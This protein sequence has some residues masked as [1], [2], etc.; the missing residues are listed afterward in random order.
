MLHRLRWQLNLA[1][2]R[3]AALQFF[4]VRRVDGETRQIGTLGWIAELLNCEIAGEF[5]QCIEVIRELEI[6]LRCGLHVDRAEDKDLVGVG[7]SRTI[8]TA[9]PR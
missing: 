9:F 3:L 4:E 2:P 6:T 7:E 8:A 1:V 5:A